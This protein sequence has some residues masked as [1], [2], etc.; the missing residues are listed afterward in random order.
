MPF[1]RTGSRSLAW[2]KRVSR[3]SRAFGTEGFW[4]LRCSRAQPKYRPRTRRG[5]PR[6]CSSPPLCLSAPRHAAACKRAPWQRLRSLHKRTSVQ[7]YKRVVRAI[8]LCASSRLRPGWGVG[9]EG[10]G[11]RRGPSKEIR[12]ESEKGPRNG[13]AVSCDP[14]G[15][16]VRQRAEQHAMS[17]CRHTL[18][19]TGDPP[20]QSL[21]CSL[22]LARVSLGLSLSPSSARRT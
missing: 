4:C 5:P 11:G 6:A 8:A 9:A 10:G 13:Q 18:A 22:V 16:R 12:R 17:T 20:R 14:R 19:T 15:G 7:A 3:T 1:T 2:R 21:E